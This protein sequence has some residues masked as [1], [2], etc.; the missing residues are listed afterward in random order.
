MV[1]LSQTPDPYEKGSFYLIQSL[2]C[3]LLC[4]LLYIKRKTF[5]KNHVHNSI[6]DM[7]FYIKQGHTNLSLTDHLHVHLDWTLHLY[8]GLFLKS[9]PAPILSIWCHTL[10]SIIIAYHQNCLL[11]VIVLLSTKIAIKSSLAAK[12]WN[13]SSVLFTP[14]LDGLC[15]LWG[16]T[17]II[18]G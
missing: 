14:I 5:K 17:L 7:H 2:V 16:I 3:G 9:K 12:K 10:L 4:S 18:Q 15:Y 1:E 6:V 8:S 11:L 13:V